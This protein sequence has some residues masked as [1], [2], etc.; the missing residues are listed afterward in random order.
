MQT[1]IASFATRTTLN[2]KLCDSL[3]LCV[4][5]GE[6]GGNNP[7]KKRKRKKKKSF[8]AV[9]SVYSQQCLIL[10]HR[11]DM[12]VAGKPCPKLT[13]PFC[14][15]FYLFRPVLYFLWTRLKVSKDKTSP[16]GNYPLTRLE[17]LPLSI[18]NSQSQ[19]TAK[20]GSPW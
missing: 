8:N 9:P 16:D 15:S 6:R 11:H 14:R 7:S 1:L 18:A 2:G 3:V 4:R 19:A 13:P 12:I 10:F 5:G 17:D 20:N